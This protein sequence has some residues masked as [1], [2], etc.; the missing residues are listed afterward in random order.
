[1]LKIRLDRLILALLCAVVNGVMSLGIFPGGTS[2]FMCSFACRYSY[3]FVFALSLY[4]SCRE[5]PIISKA[6]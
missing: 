5:F 1:M 2:S 6:F 4:K 3:A